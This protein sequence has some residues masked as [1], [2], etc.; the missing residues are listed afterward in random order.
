MRG[1]SQFGKVKLHA[2]VANREAM[3]E[4][5]REPIESGLDRCTFLF[6][7]LCVVNVKPKH[8]ARLVY[9]LCR[10]EHQSIK[11]VVEKIRGRVLPDIYGELGWRE[12]LSFV[13]N[14]HKWKFYKWYNILF[15][16]RW[17]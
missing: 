12:C 4:I 9:C 1:H 2:C 8:V 16:C 10:T 6:K 13:S 17:S 7:E 15:I 5:G 11:I 14:C 3:A